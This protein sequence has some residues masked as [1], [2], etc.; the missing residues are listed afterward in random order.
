MAV[1]LNKNRM[2]G[3]R[4]LV[5][6]VVLA[7]FLTR[8]AIPEGT[9]LYG[10]LKL[11]GFLLLMACAFGRIYSTAFIG[12][13]KNKELVTV[14]AYSMHRNPL[15]FYSLLGAA[16]VG[17]M[18][19]QVTSFAMIFGGFFLLYAG[20]IS[21]E[22]KFLEEKFGDEF[23][24]FKARVPRLLPDFRKYNAPAELLFQPKFFTKAVWDAVWWFAPVPLFELAK[25]LQHA[26]IIKPL[27]SVF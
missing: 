8:P 6:L 13:I 3:S 23:T 2:L 21:R 17:L 25:Y 11:T 16:G 7:A 22:E 27:F 15:Y 19:V 4:V 14:G 5:V 1:N 24:R 18:S 20:L 26:R 10:A 9:V 12:G